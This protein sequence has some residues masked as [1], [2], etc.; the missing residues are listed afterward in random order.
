MDA[1]RVV[2][3]NHEFHQ[4]HEYYEFFTMK[5]VKAAMKDSHHEERQ[6]LQL[7]ISVVVLLHEGRTGH[8]KGNGK[9]LWFVSC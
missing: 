2:I 7:S 3:S 6:V 1:I 5:A 9:G 8:G 4:G